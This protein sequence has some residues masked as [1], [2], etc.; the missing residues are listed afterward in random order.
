MESLDIENEL[1]RYTE[2]YENKTLK[3][4]DGQTLT[5]LGV[6]IVITGNST[7]IKCFYINELNKWDEVSPSYLEKYYEIVD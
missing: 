6:R 1:K 2:K 4:K 3:A 5:V 7:L